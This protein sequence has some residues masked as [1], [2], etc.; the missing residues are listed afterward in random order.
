LRTAYSF[1][2]GKKLPKVE[3]ENVRGLKGV[4]ETSVNIEGTEVKIAVAHGLANVE[5]V[6]NQIRKAQK[7]GK[8][9]PYHFVEVMAC[10]GGCVGGGGQSL[11]TNKKI[12]AE[13]S[14]SL[15]N[16]DERKTIKCAHEN[17]DVKKVYAE[18]FTSEETRRKILHTNFSPRNKTLINK[19]KNSRETYE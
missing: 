9:L 3:F 19:I 16:I 14:K 18:F 17:P 7:E 4:K 15:Y 10:P 2:T 11:P 8:P 5:Y 6:L 13:R 1:V 12:V